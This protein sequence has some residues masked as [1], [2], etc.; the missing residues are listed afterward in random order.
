M[1]KYVWLRQQQHPLI[2]HSR[3]LHVVRIYTTSKVPS[4]LTAQDTDTETAQITLANTIPQAQNGTMTGGNENQETTL[5]DLELMSEEHFCSSI[6]DRRYTYMLHSINMNM[7]LAA[8]IHTCMYKALCCVL[9]V[10]W[11]ILAK[12]LASI[13]FTFFSYEQL[14]FFIVGL[15][16]TLFVNIWFECTQ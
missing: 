5:P 11:S 12:A 8:C 1:Y 13:T 4:L 16:L 7:D 14:V 6:D 10:S 15:L 3:P 2:S 9:L